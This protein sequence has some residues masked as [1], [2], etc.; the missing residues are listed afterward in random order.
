MR[1]KHHEFPLQGLFI[2]AVKKNNV[3]HEKHTKPTN[4]VRGKNEDVLIF[5]VGGSYN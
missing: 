2:N 5:I 4:T 3:F 1:R